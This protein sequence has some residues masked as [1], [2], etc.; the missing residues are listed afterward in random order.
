MPELKLINTKTK[1]EYKVVSF[2]PATGLMTLV[3][4]H[5]IEFTETNDKEMLKR[6]GYVLHKDVPA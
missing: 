3:G 1:K 6:T 4:E 2:D 5:G